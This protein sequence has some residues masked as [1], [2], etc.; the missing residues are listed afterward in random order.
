MAMYLGSNLITGS[1]SVSGQ[2][3]GWYWIKYSNGT[4]EC[5]KKFVFTE[6][7]N[8]ITTNGYRS[9][10]IDLGAYPIEFV[11]VPVVVLNSYCDYKYSDAIGE[12]FIFNTQTD[13]PT[14]TS[15]GKIIFFCFRQ[16]SDRVITLDVVVK[17]IWKEI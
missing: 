6:S 14:L 10:T 9:K 13:K 1:G 8:N 11:E 2:T 16:S 4:A 3:N 15:C 17:G 7:I 5:F 12:Q